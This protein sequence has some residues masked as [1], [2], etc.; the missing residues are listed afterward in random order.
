VIPT[1]FLPEAFAM[2]PLFHPALIKSSNISRTAKV[3]ASAKKATIKEDTADVVVIYLEANTTISIS[4]V[5]IFLV[6]FLIFRHSNIH[7]YMYIRV[8]SMCYG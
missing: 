6:L 3:R 4:G 2:A 8:F 7:H 5:F 1:V